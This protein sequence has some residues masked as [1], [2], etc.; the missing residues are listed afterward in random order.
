MTVHRTTLQ[1]FTLGLVAFLLLAVQAPNV[2][3]QFPFSAQI[4]LLQDDEF[5]GS[6]CEH[7]LQ[8]FS[9]VDFDFDC[10]PLRKDCGWY[11]SYDKLSWAIT[12]DRAVIGDENA[13]V[14]SEII[15][16]DDLARPGVLP[17]LTTSPLTAADRQYR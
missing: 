2:L 7:D 3:G 14:F 8:F 17:N 16:T 6:G 4:G 10:Q 12:G 15:V 1:R 11:F 13:Q 5:C 9:P